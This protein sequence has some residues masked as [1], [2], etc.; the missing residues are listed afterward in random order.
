MV[1]EEVEFGK[2]LDS[3]EFIDDD[4]KLLKTVLSDDSSDD[5]EGDREK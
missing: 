5:P 1:D 2:W 3:I 4:G